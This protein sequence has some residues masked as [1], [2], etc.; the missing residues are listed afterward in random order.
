MTHD[1]RSRYQYDAR[2][3]DST[4]CPERLGTGGGDEANLVAMTFM[5]LWS[6]NTAVDETV[7]N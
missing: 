7:C 2:P 6:G 5:L 3:G 4:H 1:L